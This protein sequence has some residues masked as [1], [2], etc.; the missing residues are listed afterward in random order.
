MQEV[1]IAQVCAEIDK[2]FKANDF[3]RVETM[4]WPALDQFSDLP[5]LWFYAGNLLFQ[6]GRAAPA[7]LAFEKCVALDQNALVL[8]NLGA[9]YRKLNQHDNGLQ[10]L[11]AALE[12]SPDYQPALV[13]LGSM[14]VNEGCPE[15]G[16]PYLERAVALGGENPERGSTWNL[17]L[18][19][20]EAG[21]FAE[22]FELYRKGLGAERLMRTYGYDGCPEPEI[23]QPHHEGKGKT[24]IVWGEQG[25]GDEIMAATC[26]RDAMAEFDEVIFECHPRLEW[27]HRTAFPEIRLYPTRKDDHIGWPISDGIKADYKCPL[28]DLAARYR[29]TPESFLEAHTRWGNQYKPDHEEVAS[30]RAQLKA[31]A[32]G[33]PIVAL[34]TRGGVMQTARTY[35]TFRI[36]DADKLFESTDCL[37]VS[38]DYDDMMGFTEYVSEKYGPDRYRWFPAIVQHWDFNHTAAL[39]AACDMTVTVCQSAAHLAA[40]MGVPTRVMVPKRCAW[41]Y[42]PALEDGRWYWYPDDNVKLYRGDDNWD[43]VL[44]KVIEDIRGLK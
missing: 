23:L 12:R 25:I 32:N 15:L 2:A 24:L 34:A 44:V 10:V 41:R 40:A 8:A 31:I 13:N 26:I 21:R 9:A 5:Q 6:T 11:K 19:Y 1:G 20:L 37:F 35:R 17:S 22:G 39:I 29:K 42:A 16:I 18:L 7:A 3:K 38:I 14:Y 28:L 4:L 30:Y 33:R 36:P 27:L 43:D